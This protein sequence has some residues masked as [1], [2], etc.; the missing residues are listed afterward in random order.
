MTVLAGQ[1][2]LA[3]DINAALAA[4]IGGQVRGSDTSALNTTETI[5]AQSGAS[6]SSLAASSTYEVTLHAGCNIT[7]VTGQWLFA[8]RETNV[9]GTI[10]AQAVMPDSD[11]GVP[12]HFSFSFL[13][14]T[15]TATTKL[16][17][18]TIDRIGGAGNIVIQGGSYLEATYKAPSGRIATI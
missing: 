3:D 10:R 18:A 6:A 15:T 16:W 12:L 11:A 7:D 2:A 8:I 14:T 9:S 13:W 17:V 5:W 4:C 1:K